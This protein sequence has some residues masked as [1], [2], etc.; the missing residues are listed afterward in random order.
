M[1]AVLWPSGYGVTFRLC[2]IRD[3][4]PREFESRQCQLF[5]FYR[6]YSASGNVLSS[7][8]FDLK[9]LCN[10]SRRLRRIATRYRS[11]SGSI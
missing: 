5:Y 3:G 6:T 8:P 4:K 1:S 7:P 2:P 10:F 9:G 11:D